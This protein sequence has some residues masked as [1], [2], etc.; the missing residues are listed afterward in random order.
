M[1]S[2]RNLLPL[3]VA[4]AVATLALSLGV[5][6]PAVATGKVLLSPYAP[7][8]HAA[9]TAVGASFARPTHAQVTSVRV[10]VSRAYDIALKQAGSLPKGVK[11]TM[12][13]GLFK[14]AMQGKPATLAYAVTF[15]GV[16]VPSLGPTSGPGG[17]ELVVIVNARTGSGVE[18]FSYR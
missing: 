13:L 16:D 10:S 3:G 5:A 15:A 12:R 2:K 6:Y 1:G 8:P 14:D 11:V 9:L 4:A 7:F 18:A 17:H